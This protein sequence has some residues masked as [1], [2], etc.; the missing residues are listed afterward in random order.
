LLGKFEVRRNGQPIEIPSRPAQSLLAYLILNIG[1]SHRREKLA[2]L[3]WPDSDEANA[4]SNLRQTLWRL[5]QAIGD[6]SFLV[7]KVSIGFNP[8]ANYKLDVAILE[9]KAAEVQSADELISIVS[10]Y[11]GRLLP[12]F[13]DD[14][15]VLEGER[16]QAVFEHKMNLLLD[17]LVEAQ[18][19]QDILEW[20]ERWIAL[21][22]SPEPAYRALM[23]AHSG[24]GASSSMAAVFQRCIEAL[25]HDLGVEP[26][27]QTQTLYER[28]RAGEQAGRGEMTPAPLHPSQ[29]RSTRPE[30]TGRPSAAFSTRL[31]LQE[32]AIH[33][34]HLRPSHLVGRIEIQHRLS[35]HLD[36]LSRGMGSVVLLSG[37]PGIGKTRLLDET[38]AAARG[39]GW[40]VLLG[41]CHERD[42]AI[43]YLPI[44]EALEV[45][46]RR[47]APAA[48][49]RLLQ[50]AG[51]EIGVLLSD[52]AFKYLQWGGMVRPETSAR[53]MIRAEARP[54]RAVR[55]L[56]YEMAREAPV[57]LAVDDLHW[58]DP[59]TLE[60][61]H[62]LAQHTR[63]MPVFLLGTYREVELGRAHPLSQVLVE[64]N[65]ERLLARKR[66]H[67]FD[68]GETQALVAELLGGPAP[69]A[70]NE[71][72]YEQ[73]EGNPFFIEELINGLVEMRWLVWNEQ[74][75]YY[76]LIPG[77]A[78]EMLAGQVPQSIRAA[79]GLRL[80]YLDPTTQLVLGLASV[81]GRHFSLE[82]LN[83]LAATHGLSET[84]VERALANAQTAQF[85]TMLDVPLPPRDDMADFTAGPPDIEA[86]YAFDHPL[87]H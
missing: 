34:S 15:V 18:R 69:P 45:Y 39:R 38:L 52:D 36:R 42:V 32:H 55:N 51:P 30:Q 59:P 41:R 8:S 35:E 87:L 79:I 19:W 73:T 9:D 27:E 6:G 10:V 28:L 67:R 82:V 1:A 57:V 47:C 40:Q 58:A 86:D 72:I 50:A 23:V 4:R 37:E 46:A 17:R 31:T 80:E 75:H 78:I 61:L 21:G 63:D 65:R 14:W 29:T 53:L 54:M 85:I 60:L 77:V 56:L 81:I 12:G 11:K 64:L 66:L 76:Q 84:E 25:R 7:D 44:A 68:L 49:E 70:L 83:R 2:G 24:L 33:L 20:G 48:W 26:S 74:G 5:R 13:Y 22:G 43:P 62:D 16:L 3:L 71:L